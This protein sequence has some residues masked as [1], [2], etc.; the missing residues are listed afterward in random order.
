M[1]EDT[2]QEGQTA[3][4]EAVEETGVADALAAMAERVAATGE[5]AALEEAAL[6]AVDP[7]TT[8]IHT[9]AHNGPSLQT[10]RLESC[11]SARSDMDWDRTRTVH[12]S[13]SCNRSLPDDTCRCSKWRRSCT[14]R[15]RRSP[16][17]RCG[18]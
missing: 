10:V 4:A 1:A 5:V 6:Q 18:T 11:K 16:P 17:Q 13:L 8:C 15:T 12:G 7:V 14:E 3:E 2:C 9:T